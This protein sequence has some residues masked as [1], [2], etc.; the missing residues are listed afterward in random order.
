MRRC[1]IESLD[2]E[3]I[4]KPTDKDDVRTAKL[5]VA[6]GSNFTKED[7]A[8]VESAFQKRPAGP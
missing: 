4:G 2:T 3:R 5:V 1:R 8:K 6:D 7:F